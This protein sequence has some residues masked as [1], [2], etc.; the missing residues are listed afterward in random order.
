MCQSLYNEHYFVVISSACTSLTNILIVGFVNY[1]EDILCVIF[2]HKY[3]CT[4]FV[5]PDVKGNLKNQICNDFT[6]AGRCVPN[7]IGGGHHRII[8]ENIEMEFVS[9]YII[10]APIAYSDLKKW[11][12]IAHVEIS[13]ALTQ[14]DSS[15][16][17]VPNVP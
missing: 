6:F 10:S 17:I 4:M 12:F 1:V 14:F 15:V 3:I 11:K 16:Y 9:S 2:K 5:Q 7:K 13:E 8:V